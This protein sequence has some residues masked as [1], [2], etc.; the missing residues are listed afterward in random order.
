MYRTFHRTF[1]HHSEKLETG[2]PMD[3]VLKDVD[4]IHHCMNDLSKPIKEE[5]QAR[6]DRLCAEFGIADS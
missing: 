6:F 4:V 2:E 5:E 3:E 1:Y